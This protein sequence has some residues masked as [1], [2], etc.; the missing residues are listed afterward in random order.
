[1]SVSIQNARFVIDETPYCLWDDDIRQRNLDFLD[2]IDPGYFEHVAN[3]HG[4]SLE[5]DEKQY[6]ATAL[7]V[8]HF[9]GL[10][11][12]FALLCAAIQAPDCVVGWLS[13]YQNKELYEVVRKINAWGGVGVYTKLRDKDITWDAVAKLVY[14]G[15]RTG[16]DDKDAQIKKDFGRLWSRF[17]YDLIDSKNRY[18]YNSIKHGLRARMGGFHLAM[19]LED[20]PGVPAPPEKMRTV[21]SSDFGSSFFVPERLHD[22]RNFAIKRQSVNWDPQNLIYALGLIGLSIGNVIAFFKS[23]YGL[24]PSEVKYSWCTDEST[25]DEPWTRKHGSAFAI[26]WNSR[27]TEAAVTPLT[28]DEILAVYEEDDDEAEKP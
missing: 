16:D 10:E 3:L 15:L 19:G 17:S 4:E 24:S 25:Y 13:M 5:G 2:S 21:A 23:L 1:M 11:T 9:Q 27:V 28:K 18:E 14:S 8:A 12:V 20:T 7:R 22:R 26:A 6:A